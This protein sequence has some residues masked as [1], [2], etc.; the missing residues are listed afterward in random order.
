MKKKV[1]EIVIILFICISIFLL[2]TKRNAKHEYTSNL[3]Y[4]D[5]NIYV[6]FYSSNKKVAKKALETI[7]T[8]YQDYYEL[9]DPYNHYEGKTNLYDILHNTSKEEY[10]EIDSRLYEMISYGMELFEKSN[11]LLDIRMGNVIDIWKTYRDIGIGIP[12]IEEL[13]V[14]KN[15]TITDIVLKEGNLIKN[16]HPNLDLRIMIRG[17]ATE[18]VGEYLESIG[19][20][21]Y[22]INTDGNIKVGKHYNHSMYSI[23]I[24]NPDSKIGDIYKIVY[25]NNMSVVSSGGYHKYYQY[26]QKQYHSIINPNTLFPPN[27]CKSVTVLVKDSIVG[28][29]LSTALFLLPIE[30]GIQ[31]VEDMENT[32]AIWYTNN[33]TEIKTKGFT[34]YEIQ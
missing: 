10:I 4:M 33:N 3:S 12:N 13:M 32:E 16:N 31:L 6:K 1:I 21:E 8:L 25:G 26:N 15:N 28:D 30:E 20:D 24:E 2:L 19:I 29:A 23:G 27:Y 7:E 34:K 14:A 9:S 22:I 18:K 17:Y 11:G 5:I